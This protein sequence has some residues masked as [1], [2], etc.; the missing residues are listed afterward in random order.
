MAEQAKLLV[1]FGGPEKVHETVAPFLKGVIAQEVLQVGKEPEKAT[2][3]KTT[4]YVDA[5][6][7]PTQC[8]ME[9]RK[10]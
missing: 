8:P 9:D 6:D 1:A 2:L 7:I 4:E 10:D 3:L 5:A